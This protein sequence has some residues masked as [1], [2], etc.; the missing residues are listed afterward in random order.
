M[1]HAMTVGK[2]VGLGFGAV[3]LLLGVTAV[4]SYTG[5]RTLDHNASDVVAKNA[6]AQNFADREIDHL[7]WAKKV[8]ELLTDDTVTELAVQTD[9]HKCALGKWYYGDERKA[10]VH[11]VPK[12]KDA[13]SA[14]ESPHNRLHES[15]VN[16][17]KHFWQADLRLGQFLQ[18]KKVDHLAWTHKVKDA[19]LDKN[20]TGV[21]V[22]MDPRLCGLGKWILSSKT[23]EMSRK[24]EE[25]GGL[26]AAMRI[27]HEKLHGSASEISRLVSTGERERALASFRENTERFAGETLG[28]IDRTIAWNAKHTAGMLEASRIYSV[29]TKA[30]LADCQR[31]LKEAGEHV[32]D[33]V[34]ETNEE[35]H[36]SAT[37][38]TALVLT[39][40]IVAGVVGCLL[41]F[42]IARGIVGALRRLASSLSEGSDQVAGAS[43]QVSSAS[44]SLAQG[45]SE[46]AAA[47]EE[48]SASL[49]E[50]SAMTKQNAGNAQQ[51]NGLMEETTGQIGKARDAMG[52]LTVSMGEIKDASDE[53]AKIVKTIDEIAFQT[54][55]LALNAAVEAAR[56]G[57]AGKGFAV[58][59]E[60][61][62]NLAQRAGEAARNTS[63]LIET[64]VDK[65]ELG[66]SVAT[67]SADAL[68]GI[69]TSA[70]KVAGLVS[71]ISAACNEQSQG[72]DQ[73][74]D[75]VGQ[76]DS[77]TQ[78]NAAN[79]EESA[80][81]S[82]ELSAQ[83]EELNQMVADLRAM[84]DGADNA[85]QP[86]AAPAPVRRPVATAA[87]PQASRSA[88]SLIP[89]E[90]E[91]LARF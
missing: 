18:A 62:R 53:T 79:A 49:E 70:N 1:F 65:S 75:A 31:L 9:P 55:L 86:V 44:Q 74:N 47:I 85:T 39:T 32:R 38:T 7:N 36:T 19:L 81:A 30:A 54:N 28:E 42:L 48:T 66:V 23:E 88:E 21:R 11:A 59:A 60:E 82:E 71:E 77:V 52:R 61:V 13:I 35:M 67:E 50:M 3:L 27:P 78:Q 56:A 87:V 57:D 8:S 73:V 22:Q 4:L 25:F 69:I 12:I 90:E 10:A 41:A 64:S 34:A 68:E 89:L 72:I 5:I 6:L 29:D 84:V 51:A 2:K 83:A 16:I 37:A 24:Y 46:Q 15:A 45:T 26:V 20:A 63:A 33:V 43:T 58:V 91:E 40:S 17:K 80:S 14:I 76:M